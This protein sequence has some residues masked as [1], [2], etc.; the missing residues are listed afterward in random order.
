[1]APN[2]KIINE[3]T[4]NYTNGA[5]AVKEQDSYPLPEL[6]NMG[7]I[8]VNGH[9]SNEGMDISLKPDLNTLTPSTQPDVDF[10]L[11]SGT[12]SAN[13]MT[14]TDTV[15]ILPDFSQGTNANVYK[16]ENVFMTSTGQI[17][18]SNGKIPMVSK[19]LTW[20]ATP[21][22]NDDGNID[23]Y[24]HKLAYRDFAETDRWR[25]YSGSDRAQSGCDQNGRLSY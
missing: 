14:I 6:V 1:M 2:G 3:G 16:L 12:I 17:I 25:K 21:K 22:V 19:S 10:V 23:V 13:S 7:L 24:M 18:S 8:T 15:K 11:N 9:F 5:F 20:E 4:I